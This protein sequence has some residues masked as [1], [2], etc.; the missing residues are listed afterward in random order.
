MSRPSTGTRVLLLRHAETAAPDRYHG[1]ESDIALGPR[2][3]EQAEGAAQGLIRLGPTALYSS[4]ML[5]ARQT[6]GPIARTLGLEA[7][8]VPALHERIMGPLGGMLQSEGRARYV[9]SMEAWK[10]GDLAATHEGGESYLQIR[11]RVVPPFLALA[12]SHPGETIVVV[13]HGMVIRVLLSDLLGGPGPA[14]FDGFGI[15]Y[16]AINDL[17]FDGQ[18]WLAAALNRPVGELEAKGE[19]G[20]GPLDNLPGGSGAS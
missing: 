3:L 20:P 4:A 11:D 14:A 13:A 18:A 5:R 2:G 12:R 15:D 1:S 10:A 7:I 6:A 8:V 16:V 19:S 9:A 17:R